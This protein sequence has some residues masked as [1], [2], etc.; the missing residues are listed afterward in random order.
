MKV[1]IKLE[2]YN[3]IYGPF[4]LY[5]GGGTDG[6]QLIAENVSFDSMLYGYDCTE[7][8]NDSTYI[9]VISL[10]SYLCSDDAFYYFI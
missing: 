10:D 3:D 6:E 9:R 1:Q 2:E 4:N 7:I 8:P 5:Y